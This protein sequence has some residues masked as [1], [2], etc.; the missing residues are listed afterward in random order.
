MKLEYVD[1]RE[2]L[3]NIQV[4]DFVTHP[5]SNTNTHVLIRYDECKE[6]IFDIEW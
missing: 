1:L 4:L 6:L 3:K 2:G 5:S